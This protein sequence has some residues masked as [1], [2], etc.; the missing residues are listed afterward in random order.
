MTTGRQLEALLC[1]QGGKNNDSY[2]VRSRS[3]KAPQVRDVLVGSS[4]VSERLLSSRGEGKVMQK[5]GRAC[6]N[7]W[8]GTQAD[9]ADWYHKGR[10]WTQEEIE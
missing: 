7:T 3:R 5:K 1:T 6:S 10:K 2:P 4:K 9:F 8:V